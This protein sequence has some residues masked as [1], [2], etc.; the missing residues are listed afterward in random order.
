MYV[1]PP[2]SSVMR[3]D[4][5][6]FIELLFGY[7]LDFISVDGSRSFVAT[8]QGA[9]P[10]QAIQNMDHHADHLLHREHHVC[11]S[12][13]VMT[14]SDGQVAAFLLLM[15]IFAAPWEALAAIGESLPRSGRGSG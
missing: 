15:P 14:A 13:L 5:S 12:R 10:R 9:A 3:T 6:S 7:E 11:V 2:R 1:N 8:R 4:K